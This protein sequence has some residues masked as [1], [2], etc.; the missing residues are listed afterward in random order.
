LETTKQGMSRDDIQAAKFQNLDC[1]ATRE[2]VPI[3][4]SITRAGVPI[5]KE[6]L[7][8]K[9][10]ELL[11]EHY[12]KQVKEMDD[13]QMNSTLKYHT[14]LR[15]YEE[16]ILQ[17]LGYKALHKLATEA[18]KRIEKEFGTKRFGI[19]ECVEENF[20]HMANK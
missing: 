18:D 6:S 16:A 4:T 15:V 9:A 14:A 20:E 3:D 11:I 13:D 5:M 1:H 10:Y 17:A 12:E 7:I 19:A 8:I 2:R